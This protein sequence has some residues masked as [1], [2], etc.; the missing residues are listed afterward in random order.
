MDCHALDVHSAV[1]EFKHE[2]ILPATA[3]LLQLQMQLLVR[4]A[5]LP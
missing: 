1:F 3:N 4:S 5:L 2:A